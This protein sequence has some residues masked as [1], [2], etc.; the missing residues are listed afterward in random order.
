ML[1][2][3]SSEEDDDDYNLENDDASDVCSNI[4]PRVHI[5]RFRYSDCQRPD[6]QPYCHRLQVAAPILLL[7]R[8]PSVKR[9]RSNV[10]KARMFE[11]EV[12]RVPSVRSELLTR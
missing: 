1:G 7:R 8:T 6:G 12:R 2:A 5:S 4:R 3:S 11:G 10:V 9:T